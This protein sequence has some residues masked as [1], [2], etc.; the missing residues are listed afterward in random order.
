MIV[1]LQLNLLFIN[2]GIQRF[3]LSFVIRD[4]LFHPIVVV[5]RGLG[6]FASQDH[7]FFGVSVVFTLEQQ[8]SA[9]YVFVFIGQSRHSSSTGGGVL[10][11]VRFQ[12]RVLFEQRKIVCLSDFQLCHDIGK[13]RKVFLVGCGGVLQSGAV[14]L[15][16]I[17]RGGL[18]FD[19][20]GLVGNCG[21]L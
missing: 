9:L 3:N 4:F 5:G 6:Q 21:V 7:D 12:R 15:Q 10:C 18:C 11:L 16:L 19:F 20:N 2:F 8:F 13:F 17:D 1:F 14:P